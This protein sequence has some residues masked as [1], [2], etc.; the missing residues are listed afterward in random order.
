L[1][2]LLL[3]RDSDETLKLLIAAGA[4]VNGRDYDAPPPLNIFAGSGNIA[5][6]KILL[7]AKAD[8]NVQG[9]SFE[10]SPFLSALAT[11]DLD[12]VNLLISAGAD[13]TVRVSNKATCLHALAVTCLADGAWTRGSLRESSSEFDDTIPSL[14]EKLNEIP[15]D[16]PGVFNALINAKA[17]ISARNAA[18][19][20][21]LI[22]ASMK[23][24]IKAMNA[25][26]AAGADPNDVDDIQMSALLIATRR[27]CQ[28]AV[29][30]LIAAGADVNCVTSYGDTPLV[31]AIHRNNIDMVADMIVAGADVSHV[32]S[33]G[34]TPLLA[35]V[36]DNYVDVVYALIAAGA[37]VNHVSYDHTSLDD[38][39][40]ESHTELIAILKDAGALTWEDLMVQ[41][42]ELLS[43]D[44][45]S[46]V[47]LNT[48]QIDKASDED[49]ENAMKL[50]VS[51]G[52]LTNVKSLLA[53][54]INPSL[55]F[56]R[57]DLLSVASMNGYTD[58]VEA[59]LAA[60]ADI[61]AKDDDEGLTALQHA[62]KNKHRDIVA[63][64]L[65]KA[66]ELKNAN[67]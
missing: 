56:I 21:P 53:A 1:C 42:N 65:A 66:N 12:M 59:L 31:A 43:V 51:L 16:Y 55:R 13:L 27:G 15:C 32:N 57:A 24:N 35:A 46:R 52:S 6:A 50:C 38:A 11:G 44:N 34:I 48:E 8:V 20:T 45:T 10:H 23:S 28:D 40:A 5:C 17:D 63:M 22:V 62:A 39:L 67:K 61:N 26:L 2:T 36:N 3:T 33:S 30:A 19:M 41:T 25:L 14:T 58:I 29:R 37:N 4:D 9:R 47:I 54:G 18:G 7:D 60:G 64:I 49:R